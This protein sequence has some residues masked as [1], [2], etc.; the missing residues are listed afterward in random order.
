MRFTGHD[1]TNPI[2]ASAP[3]HNSSNPTSPEVTTSV[4]CCQILRLG[5]FDDDDIIVDTPG[6]ANHSPITMDE[7]AAGSAG[8]V[9]YQNFGE[10]KRSPAVRLLSLLTPSSVILETF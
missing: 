1:A 9:T 7:S 4:G 10:G 3:R 6:L 2:N 5:A 8:A